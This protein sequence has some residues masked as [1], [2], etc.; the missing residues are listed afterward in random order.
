MVLLRFLLERDRIE[1]YGYTLCAVHCEHGI[2]GEESVEDMRFVQALCKEWGVELFRFFA[3]CPT[4]AREK[5][6]SLE[7]AAREFRRECFDEI[8]KEGKADYIATAH[9][10][11]DEAE[12]VL[13]RL[14]RG[15]SLRGAGGIRPVDGYFIRPLLFMRKQDISAAAESYGL[16]YRV[17]STNLQ[18]DATRNKLRLEVL[19]ALE[20][21]VAGAVENLARFAEIA[22]Q[23]DELL[24][25]FSCELL[26]EKEG[27]PFVKFSDKK[28]LFTRACLT[29][30]RSLGLEKDYNQTHLDALYDLQGNQ[31][32][33]LCVLPKNLLAERQSDGLLFYQRQEELPLQKPQEKGYA[34]GGFDGGRYEVKLQNAPPTD[35]EIFGKILWLDEEKL[36]PTAVFRFRKEGDFIDSFA[37]GKKSLK[38]LFNEKKIPPK[39]REYLPLI[40]EPS[41]EV[42]VVC[43]VEI[44]K[45]VKVDGKGGIYLSIRKRTKNE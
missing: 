43:G 20:N 26:A 25:E 6:V 23:D 2:R 7:T 5:K 21:A 13:F 45:K 22:R 42:Y 30:L 27:N 38:K 1:K 39:E 4:L 17:D 16:S 18:T 35:E 31:R 10:Q 33:A 3:D 9:H 15:C 32:G 12:T 29:A 11:N 19:P 37:S 40:A 41:G 8:I 34:K 28:P 44:S 14:A 36:P 24:Y